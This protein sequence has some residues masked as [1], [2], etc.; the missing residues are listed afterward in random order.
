MIDL[1]AYK[2]SIEDLFT[3]NNIDRAEV[4]ILFCEALNCDITGLFSKTKLSKA[5]QNKIDMATKKRLEGMPIQKIFKRA[6]FYNNV[7]FVNNNVLCPRPETELLVEESLK[8]VSKTSKVLDLCTGS[9]AIAISL[10]LQTNANITA[11]DISKK[12]LLVA[13]KNAKNL[14][15]NINFVCSNMFCGIKQKFNVIVSNPP[16]IPSGDIKNLDIEVK[17]FDPVISLDGGADG[18]DFYK[19]IA[20][21]AKNYL[22]PFGKILLEVGAGEAQSVKNLLLQNGFDCYIKKDY[23]KID[24]IVVGELLW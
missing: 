10:G 2:K 21:N 14:G 18:L 8:Y 4:N 13:K 16:Y 7:F 23:N 11:S 24:R 17:N 15:A 19:I 3:K 22:L 12:A 1:F 20:Q 5:Q 6:Y 9:G